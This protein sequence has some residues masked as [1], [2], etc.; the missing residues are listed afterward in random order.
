MS[1]A[2]EQHIFWPSPP[3]RK[4]NGDVNQRKQF[5]PACASSATWRHLYQE[6][7]AAKEK[8][9]KVTKRPSVKSATGNMANAG[10]PAVHSRITSQLKGKNKNL[11]AQQTKKGKQKCTKADLHTSSRQPDSN[12]NDED[13]A[14]D[15]P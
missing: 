7:I 3:K 6:N 9:V 13:I 2:F 1:S 12:K 4:K 15:E 11:K 14:D 10:S 8:I 5:F